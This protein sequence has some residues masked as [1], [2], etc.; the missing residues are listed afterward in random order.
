MCPACITQIGQ[1]TCK[2]FGI[3]LNKSLIHNVKSFHLFICIINARVYV[4]ISK[5]L[6]LQF[7]R[8]NSNFEEF[9]LNFKEMFLP[10]RADQ[11]VDHQLLLFSILRMLN[12]LWCLV[13]F[14]HY[15]HF[16]RLPY[17]LL[18]PLLCHLQLLNH[19][20]VHP[21]PSEIEILTQGC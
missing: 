8:N 21:L 12:Q 13:Y 20:P 15:R 14:V 16:Q 19:L 3:I 10:D 11:R 2:V 4:V 1:F 9:K 5:T 18:A 6:R 17:P 7:Y